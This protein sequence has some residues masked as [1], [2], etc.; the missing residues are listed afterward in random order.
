M[1]WV[2]APREDFGLSQWPLS[3]SDSDAEFTQ[4]CTAFSLPYRYYGGAEAV[5][6]ASPL[7]AGRSSADA[8]EAEFS[9]ELLEKRNAV[10]ALYAAHGGP[11]YF[12]L[13]PG[14][15]GQVLETIVPYTDGAVVKQLSDRATIIRLDSFVTDWKE[16]VI[17]GTDHACANSDRLVLD[18]R[19]NSGGYV[20]QTEWLVTHLFPDRTLPRDYS[21]PGRYLGSNTGRNELVEA[22]TQFTADII[23]PALG[24]D[25]WVGYEAACYV[26]P[27]TN[28]PLSGSNWNAVDTVVEVRGSVAET[29]SPLFA[30][31]NF[32]DKYAPGSD[33]IAC[34]GKFQDD[35]LIVLSNGTGAS[36]G[37]FFPE[38]IREQ[39][40]V[41]TAGGYLGET[42]ASGI[43]R[44]GAVW[45]MVNFESLVEQD[46]YNY[47]GYG[48]ATDPLP[49]MRRD[50]EVYIE[51]PAAYLPNGIDLHVEQAPVGDVHIEVW[52]DSPASD[53]Y[54][55]D[56]AI[57]AVQKKKGKGKP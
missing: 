31:R 52:A 18:M 47:F 44:G 56:R 34:P 43:A 27:D 16:E 15:Q 20:S 3:Y 30:F 36:A 50:V 49:L 51:Q 32:D 17:A 54:V 48:P 29:L 7:A 6:G 57:N 12:E 11:G 5:A 9:R 21:I 39:A 46:L 38:L 2:F 25:C 24:Y 26:E 28:L 33:G 14:R 10:R 8:G 41:V 45:R 4:R 37:H 40:T 13:P 22:A 42:L 1:P 19:G 35:T 23:T 53:G 55:Y